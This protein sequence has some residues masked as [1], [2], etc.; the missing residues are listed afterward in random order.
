MAATATAGAHRA[1]V[2]GGERDRAAAEAVA[3]ALAGA[4]VGIEARVAPDASPL[5]GGNFTAVVLVGA[6][7]AEAQAGEAIARFVRGGGGLVALAG[8][9]DVAALSD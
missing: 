4:G 2:V 1:L 6:S 8:A 3:A 5:A 9:F 7:G